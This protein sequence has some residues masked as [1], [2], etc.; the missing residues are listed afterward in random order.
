MRVTSIQRLLMVRSNEVLYEYMLLFVEVY[1]DL[2][3]AGR[4]HQYIILPTAVHKHPV[5]TYEATY[6]HHPDLAVIVMDTSTIASGTSDTR[7][8]VVA[9]LGV[10]THPSSLVNSSCNR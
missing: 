1:S 2:V 7:I 3:A 10:D 6:S 5:Y 8:V 4:R 9:A